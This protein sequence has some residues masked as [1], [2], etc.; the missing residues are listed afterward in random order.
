MLPVCTGF[1]FSKAVNVY[2]T[3]RHE[4]TFYFRELYITR[5]AQWNAVQVQCGHCV[6]LGIT[7]CHCVSLSVTL[8]HWVSLSLCV[9]ACHCVSLCVTLCHCVS[10]CVTVCHCVSPC[11][12]LCHCVSPCVT[13]SLAVTGCQCVSL[14]VSVGTLLGS[15]S[16]CWAFSHCRTWWFRWAGL[17]LHG[18]STVNV[19]IRVVWRDHCWSEI[20]L[21]WFTSSWILLYT[22]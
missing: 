14:C 12:T 8:C 16:W 5:H 7:V 21:V 17:R 22:D 2:S 10:L 19:N 6:S 20:N 4:S 9:T 15:S 18:N 3:S 13:L 1:Y 11:V